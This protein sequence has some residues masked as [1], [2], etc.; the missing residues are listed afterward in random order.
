MID[1]GSRLNLYTYKLMKQLEHP[2]ELFDPSGWIK[3]KAYDDAG[4][5]SKGMITLPL[6]VGPV[7]VETPCQVLDLDIPYNILLGHPWIHSLQAVPSTYHQCLKFPFNSREITIKCDRQPFSYCKLLEGK[8]SYHYLLNKPAPPP[9][10]DTSKLASTSSQEKPKVKIVDSDYGEY[11]LED[12]LHVGKF[13]LSPK[14]FSKAKEIK[15]D[16]KSTF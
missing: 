1:S 16:K 9:P 13:P 14:S 2:E 5:V 6:Q 8:H 15:K 4:R 12:V 7:T 11:K 3:I 10:S